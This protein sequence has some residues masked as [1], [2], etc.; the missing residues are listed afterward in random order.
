MHFAFLFFFMNTLTLADTLK[1]VF[2]GEVMVLTSD[3]I[4]ALTFDPR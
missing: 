1:E 3:D 2:N 4:Q